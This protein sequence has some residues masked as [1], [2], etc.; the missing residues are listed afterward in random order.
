MAVGAVDG[1]CEL[2]RIP[3]SNGSND[4]LQSARNSNEDGST[5][6]AKGE[7]ATCD[8]VDDEVSGSEE[9]WMEG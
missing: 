4:G 8:E 3:V 6:N 2:P 1:D 9:S 7:D 5:K